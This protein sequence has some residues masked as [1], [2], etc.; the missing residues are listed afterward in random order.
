MQLETEYNA[1]KE[2]ELKLNE[3]LHELTEN[4]RS[5]AEEREG[6]IKEIEMKDKTIEEL[7]DLIEL[8]ESKEGNR[9]S[10]K[11]SK[12]KDSLNRDFSLRMSVDQSEE[13]SEMAEASYFSNISDVFKRD[14]ILQDKMKKGKTSR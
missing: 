5:K 2:S 9:E 10:I 4:M 1:S 8:K 7:R 14:D 6:L 3:L 12:D 11:S 13:F